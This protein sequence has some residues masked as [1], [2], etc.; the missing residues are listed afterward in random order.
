MFFPG[1]HKSSRESVALFWFLQT[2]AIL[3]LCL[4]VH[5]QVNPLTVLRLNSGFELNLVCLR[6]R[7]FRISVSDICELFGHIGHCTRESVTRADVISSPCFVQS[8]PILCGIKTNGILRH[9]LRLQKWISMHHFSPKQ[10]HSS[11]DVLCHIIHDSI[12]RIVN[13]AMIGGIAAIVTCVIVVYG[14]KMIAIPIV[15]LSAKIRFMPYFVL[16]VN[17]ASM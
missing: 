1:S 12:M 11:N 3:F 2:L 17:G 4:S 7:F 13:S 15:S 14:V 9:F 8:V 5:S 10:K 6:R 16:S